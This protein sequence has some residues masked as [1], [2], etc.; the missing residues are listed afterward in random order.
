MELGVQILLSLS[1]VLAV[2]VLLLSIYHGTLTSAY[3]AS[4]FRSEPSRADTDTTFSRLLVLIPAHEE[5]QMI[6]GAIRSIQASDYPRD[7]VSILVAADG[8]S[9]RTAMRARELGVRVIER[10]ARGPGG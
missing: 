3:L 10:Q 7:R 2:A 4:R 6:G 5:E 9:D 1:S 8:C